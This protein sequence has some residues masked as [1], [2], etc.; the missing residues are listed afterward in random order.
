MVEDAREH[1]FL[2]ENLAIRDLAVIAYLG[3]PLITSRGIE[4]GALCAIDTS[5]RVWSAEEV[6][7]LRDL[8]ATA[9]SLIEMRPSLRQ[10]PP[11]E[12][13]TA[14]LPFP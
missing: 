1:P 11:P 8:A 2:R 4:I 13:Q 12:E 14:I 6:A 5:P 9:V 10:V 7:I 3:V